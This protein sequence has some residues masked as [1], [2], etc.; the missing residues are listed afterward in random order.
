MRKLWAMLVLTLALL[1]PGIA[2]AA[3]AQAV[4]SRFIWTACGL[5]EYRQIG[6]ND[7]RIMRFRSCMRVYQEK[8]V[9]NPTGWVNKKVNSHGELVCK[10]NVPHTTEDMAARFARGTLHPC[11]MEL[12]LGSTFANGEDVGDAQTAD[13][14]RITNSGTDGLWVNCLGSKCSTLTPY[15][16]TCQGEDAWHARYDWFDAGLDNHRRSDLVHVSRSQNFLC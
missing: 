13:N 4:E 1:L 14:W 5:Y 2:A 15:W 3:P 10:V 9:F 7:S 11:S 6:P 8:N 12:V 16:D